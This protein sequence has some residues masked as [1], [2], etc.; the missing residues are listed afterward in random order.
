MRGR[1]ASV[2]ALCE[3]LRRIKYFP[4]QLHVRRDCLVG[5]KLPNSLRGTRKAY[6]WKGSGLACACGAVLA[7]PRIRLSRNNPGSALANWMLISKRIY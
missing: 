1:H 6:A 5:V 3:I 2:H 7:Q 4:A